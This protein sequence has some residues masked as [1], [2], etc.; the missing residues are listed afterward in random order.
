[1]W[2]VGGA[3]RTASMGETC[4]A[5]CS[6]VGGSACWRG[7]ERLE[8]QPGNCSA[9]LG[10]AGRRRQEGHTGEAPGPGRAEA[11]NSS[12]AQAVIERDGIAARGVRVAPRQQSAMP[13]PWP[14][15]ELLDRQERAGEQHEG[16]IPEAAVNI[17]P[18]P[19]LQ[20]RREAEEFDKD[21]DERT[22]RMPVADRPPGC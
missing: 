20:R 18:A 16:Y 1:M 15:L 13:G 11:D 8:L 6:A 21:H 7:T 22:P 14:A 9:G 10:M 4:I 5:L 17:R 2:S 3:G 19:A 12:R